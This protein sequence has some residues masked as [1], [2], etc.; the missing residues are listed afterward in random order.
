MAEKKQMKEIK[1]MASW[2]QMVE[3]ENMTEIEL[4]TK[5]RVE[6]KLINRT[7]QGAKKPTTAAKSVDETK[8]TTM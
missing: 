1:K 6:K 3:R 5:Q 8:R 4:R 7:E 2:K